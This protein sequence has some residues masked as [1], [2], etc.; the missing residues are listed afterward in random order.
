M[1]QA[2]WILGGVLLSL[3]F[4]A[5]VR[6]FQPRNEL[7]V[8]GIALAP[9]A[10]AYVFFAL[11]S[12]A[13]HAIP[14]ELLGVLLFGG[15]G[16]AGLWRWPVLIALGWAGHVAWDL[17]S[18]GST[19]APYAPFWWPPLCVGTDLFLAGYI[20]ALVWPQKS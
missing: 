17:A 12:G 7:I 11:L 13:T 2:L 15:L 1:E 4:I 6:R 19:S 16:L 18:S 8:Y 9:T 14:F 3:G 5:F 20:T 10:G